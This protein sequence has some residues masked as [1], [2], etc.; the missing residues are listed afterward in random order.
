VTLRREPS[1]KTLS[2]AFAVVLALAAC[3]DQ[4]P[5]PEPAPEP[6]ASVPAPAPDP[7]APVV[8]PLDA[9]APE[10]RATRD[11]LLAAASASDWDAIGALIPDGFSS[12]FGG[13][14]DHVAYYRS[15]DTD[16]AAV[17]VDLLE[18]P[19]AQDGDLTVWPDLH[20]RAPFDIDDEERG[21]LEEVY[22]AENVQDWIAA[23]AYLG[24]RI[25]IAADGE[26]IFLIA[27]D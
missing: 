7:E 10:V 1:L 23:G 27:G 20:A 22:G 25:G 18:G 5:A 4:D 16:V 12:S 11:A 3:S 15:L 13:E 26:W 21:A 14:E 9:L 24:W 8:D 6:P 2:A 19:F 17:I